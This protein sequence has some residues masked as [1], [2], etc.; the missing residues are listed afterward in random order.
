MADTKDRADAIGAMLLRIQRTMAE[1]EAGFPHYAD[2]VTGRWT[3]SPAGDWTGGFWVGELW[4]AEQL[5]GEGRYHDAAISWARRLRPRASSE[6][7]FRGFLFWYGAA[8]G[9]ILTGDEEARRIAL[10]GATG[11]ADLYDP[12]ARAIPLGST[13]EE[14]SSVGRNEANIDGVPGGTPLLAWAAANGGPASMR[15]MALA[16]AERHIELCVRDDGSVCQSASFDPQTGSLVRRYTH[17][18]IHDQSTWT[19]AQAWAM[20]GFAQAMGYAHEPFAEVATRVAD[21]WL[22]RIPADGVAYWDFDAPPGPGTERDT[23]GTAIA[24]AALLKLAVRLPDRAADYRHAAERMVD[25]LIERH[26]TPV[27]PADDRLVGILDDGCY[28][29]RIGLATRAE[30]IW[31]DYFLF[32]SLLVLGGGLDTARI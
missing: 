12:V 20:L 30:L 11:L 29:R 5:T 23:S 7:I 32:E 8:I 18:G 2:P 14:A 10:D 4:L 6:T 9:A 25:A 1:A 26:L 21:W 13:A 17:K 3:R 31:G 28:N 22:E 16:H 19:R 24:A 27:S 15:E